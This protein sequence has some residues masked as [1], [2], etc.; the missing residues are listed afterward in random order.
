MGLLPTPVFKAFK[1]PRHPPQEQSVKMMQRVEA[2]KSEA[3]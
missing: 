2:F 3:V 1:N